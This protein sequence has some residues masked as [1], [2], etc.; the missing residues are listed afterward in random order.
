[1]DESICIIFN[2]AAKGSK[3]ERLRDRVRRVTRGAVV[4]E[5]RT[6]HDGTA[7]AA[8]AVKEGFKTIVAAGGDGTI[9]E[10][11]NGIAGSAVTLGVLPIGTMNVF[12]LDLG[13]PIGID[14]AWDVIRAG[15]AR[16]IDLPNANGRHW[17]QMAGVGFDAQV[18]K[19]TDPEVRKNLGP[20]SYVLTAALVAGRSPPRLTVAADGQGRVDGCFVLVGNGRYYGG[21]YEI[22]RGG[23]LDDGQLDVYVF[24][25]MSHIDVIRYIN[26]IVFGAHD[27][28]PDVKV[29]RGRR[30]WVEASGRA[31]VE[32]DGE[33][34]GYTPVVFSLGK[35]KLRVLAPTAKGRD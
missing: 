10:V 28:L 20:L 9:N 2:P 27:R 29:L 14:K 33:L 11:V 24:Q 1:M 30:V 15:H 5:T 7:L 4:R 17:V 3:A 22:F 25:R 26:G 16:S 13:I 6:Q 18:V 32:V 23:R 19:E 21:P 8:T 12:A 35:S 31:P 34:L